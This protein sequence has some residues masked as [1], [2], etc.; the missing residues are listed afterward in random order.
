MK[1]LDHNNRIHDFTGIKTRKINLM[2]KYVMILNYV[3]LYL[4]LMK[5]LLLA[6]YQFTQVGTVI[7][8]ICQFKNIKARAL[9]ILFLILCYKGISFKIG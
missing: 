9:Y 7:I 5:T 8:G 1:D 3:F 4:L 6:N 2:K